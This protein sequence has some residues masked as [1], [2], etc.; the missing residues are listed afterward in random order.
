MSAHQLPLFPLD[1]VLFPGVPIFL[2]IF[3]PRYRKMIDICIN[4]RLPFGVV[5]LEKREGEEPVAVPS[6]IGCSAEIVQVERLDNGTLNIVA[7]G[8]DRFRIL[9]TNSMEPYLQGEVELL[10]MQISGDDYQLE[11]LSSSLQG[12]LP[13]YVETLK[14][15]G[16]FEVQWD[17]L[18]QDPVELAYLA[19]YILQIESDQ[20][21][22]FLNQHEALETLRSIEGTYRTEIRM[23]QGLVDQIRLNPIDKHSLFSL[24]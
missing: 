10:P 15:I 19:A 6:E 18:P 22:Q 3:E 7:V 11:Q 8:Q 23:L 21:Q 16:E 13:V 9:N 17:D 20:K 14:Q 1:T 4:E 24:N 5:H 12:L 2:H